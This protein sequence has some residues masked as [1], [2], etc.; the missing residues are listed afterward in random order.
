MLFLPGATWPAMVTSFASDVDLPRLSDSP[1]AATVAFTALAQPVASDP[2][3]AVP[4]PADNP[5][6]YAVPAL[7][8]PEFSVASPPTP[9]VA[10][11]TVAV[12]LMSA[13]TELDAWADAMADSLRAERTVPATV[14]VSTVAPSGPQFPVASNPQVGFFVDRFTRERREVVGAWLNRSGS[15]LG[16]IR[17]TMKKHGLP[18][19]LAFT[20]MIESGFNPAAASH[21]GA[22]GLWQFMAATARRYGLRVDGWVDERLDP[23][24]STSAAA[25][26]LRDLYN[27]FGSWSLAQAAYNAGE[28]TIA[29]AIRATGS[30]DFW[31][32]ARTGFLR[33]ETKEFVPQIHAATI[34][35]RE[36]ARFG[37]VPVP[38]AAPAVDRVSVPGETDLRWLSANT[39]IPVDALRALNPV[40]LRGITPPGSA[41]ELRVPAG[42]TPE[43]LAALDRPQR[44]PGGSSVVRARGDRAAPVHVVRPRDT[45]GSIAR[46]YGVSAGDVVRWNG[47]ARPESIRP[48]DRLRVA[49]ER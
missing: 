16:M 34:I 40:L 49:A 43:I 47:L 7:W 25:A 32:L 33:R 9:A 19:D 29:R 17:E 30:S 1:P 37:F 42:R 13:V 6:A 21:A 15:F 26:Y 8:S 39:G 45:V 18:E 22:K 35:G 3:S 41:F 46:R 10:L 11:P 48:G 38:P 14:T 4:L 23:E 27:L 28:N 12:P 20:A 24:K 2:G 5:E 36:P 44:A 31:A